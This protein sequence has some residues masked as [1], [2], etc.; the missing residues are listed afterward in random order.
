VYSAD[1]CFVTGTFAGV[2]PVRSVDGRV[3]G[4]GV[5]GPVSERLQQLYV[6]LMEDYSVKGRRDFTGKDSTDL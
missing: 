1:E 2:I 3:I 6:K 5:R 4:K